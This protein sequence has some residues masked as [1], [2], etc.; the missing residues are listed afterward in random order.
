MSLNDVWKKSRQGV[1]NNIETQPKN[2][3]NPEGV[4]QALPVKIMDRRR[5]RARQAVL[6]DYR[7]T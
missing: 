2:W 1:L 5:I 7:E 4:K 6:K 3:I